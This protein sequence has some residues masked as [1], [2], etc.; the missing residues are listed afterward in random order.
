MLAF[1]RFG[2]MA[3]TRSQPLVTVRKSCP[4]SLAALRGTSAMFACDH[5]R[6][7]GSHRER[8]A[9]EHARRRVRRCG[10]RRKWRGA[11]RHVRT[12]GGTVGDVIAVVII[13][14]LLCSSGN[15][16]G[17]IM[18]SRRDKSRM[19]MRCQRRFWRVALAR[20]MPPYP[21][22]SQPRTIARNGRGMGPHGGVQVRRSAQG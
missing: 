22:A 11:G 19:D 14:I 16:S 5:R 20:V 12:R 13:S 18:A 17:N 8:L 2:G 3:R 15:G 21:L 6:G 9:L 1:E 4:T 7:A 10:L